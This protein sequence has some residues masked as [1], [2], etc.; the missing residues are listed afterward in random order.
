MN[1]NLISLAER[2]YPVL[3]DFPSDGQLRTDEQRDLGTELIAAGLIERREI[4]KACRTCGTPRFDHGWF[5]ITAAGRLF[6]AAM[7]ARTQATTQQE[8]R[9]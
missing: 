7:E 6:M 4:H 5:H 8:E 2:L 9:P 3:R 1:N